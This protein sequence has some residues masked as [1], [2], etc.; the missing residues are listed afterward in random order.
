MSGRIHALG[1]LGRLFPGAESGPDKGVN[2]VTSLNLADGSV[3]QTP[4][5]MRGGHAAMGM[6][7]GR[8]LCLA[9]HE[10]KSLVLDPKHG[11][12]ADLIAPDAYVYSGHGLIVPHRNIFVLTL[13]SETQFS[14]A[15]V[16]VLHVHD[17]SNLELID[18]ISTEGL[19]PHEIHPIPGT[20][21]LALSH[22]GDIFAERRPFEHNVVDPKLTILDAGTFRPKRHYPQKE[23]NAM[24]THMRVDREGWAY[25]VLTQY[26]KWPRL[27]GTANSDSLATASRLLDEATGRKRDYPLP[28][29]SLAERN[30][31]VPL[32]FVRVNTQTGERPDYRCW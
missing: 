12:I 11:A 3:I 23:F 28:Y 27:Y 30:F 6:G 32:P 9:Q 21:E 8:I 31:P 18:Q 13:R 4:V 17:L 14:A 15:N 19:Q 20:D 7:D 24:V 5:Q 22:Y 25:F 1:G 29:Q 16:G 10:N 26:I 2:V